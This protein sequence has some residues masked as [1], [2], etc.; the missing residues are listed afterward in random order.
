MAEAE[1]GDDVLGDDPT[2]IRL[3]EYAAELF[4]KEAGLYLPSGTMSNQVALRAQTT[5]RRRDLPARQGAHRRERAGRRRRAVGPADADLRLRRRHARPRAARALLPPRRRRAPPAA[6]RWWPSRTP[7]TTAAAS[8]YPLDKIAPVARVLRPPR[9]DPAPGRRPRLQR[10]R[11]LGRDAARDRRAVR[12]GERLPVEGPR[13]AGR[14]GA[15]RRRGD[16]RPRATGAQALR[17]RHAA[18]GHH[19]RRRPLRPRA[20]RRAPRRRPSPR[21]GAR[22]APR[23]VPGLAVDERKLQTNMVFADTHGVGLPAAKFVELLGA[24]GVLAS[25]RRP[26]QCASSPTS[27]S[28][29]VRSSRPARSWRA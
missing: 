29:T 15:A 20:Q 5:R 6:R 2:V 14:L 4:G 8:C 25:T 16:D 1:V 11:G 13:R 28:T 17:R 24:E 7:T 26:G 18:G 22:R 27:T 12:L 3:Q 21:P 23:R 10:R 19:R 9:H